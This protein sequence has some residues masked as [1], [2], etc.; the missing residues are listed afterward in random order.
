MQTE[1]NTR[2]RFY[3]PY[4]FLIIKSD[5]LLQGLREVFTD[6][7]P[8]DFIDDLREWQTFAM[9][10]EQSAYEEGHAREDLLEF[11]TALM[12]LSEALWLVYEKHGRDKAANNLSSAARVQ[13]QLLSKKETADPQKVIQHFCCTFSKRYAKT[14]LLDLLEAV[15]TYEGERKIYKGTLIWMY[16]HLHYLVKAAYILFKNPVRSL[17]KITLHISHSNM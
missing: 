17:P 5:N 6:Y 15:I 16:R 1:E 3:K 14:E 2:K 10:N 8:C 9:I 13:L 4:D 12:K 11:I 7:H